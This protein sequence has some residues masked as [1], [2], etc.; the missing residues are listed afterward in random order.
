MRTLAQLISV[1]LHPLLVPTYLVGVLCFA[2]PPGV[3]VGLGLDG[4]AVLLR[5]WGLTFWLPALLVAGLQ[6]LGLINSVELPERRQ[7]PLPLL[8]TALAFGAA[9]LRLGQIYHAGNLAALLFGMA[10]AALLTLFITLFWKISAHGVGMGGAVGL[11][12]VFVLNERLPL[13]VAW[14]WWLLVLLLAAAVAWA[15]LRLA[16]HTP[17]QVLAGLAL[18]TGVSLAVALAEWPTVAP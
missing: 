14:A 16:A 4:R 18:G 2:L 1:V 7:R 6:Q 5:T 10:L 17:A 3:V 11:F 13:T 12:T 9:A 8:I 15:R